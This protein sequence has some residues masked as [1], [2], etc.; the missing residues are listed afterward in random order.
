MHQIQ[1]VKEEAY[2]EEHSAGGSRISNDMQESMEC[3][4]DIEVED[5]NCFGLVYTWIKS[6]SKPETSILK[7]LDRAM[8]NS[9][10]LDKYG[11][12]PARFHPFLISDHSPVVLHIPNSIDKKKKSFI[13]SNFIVDKSQFKD[14]VKRI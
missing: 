7:K 13:V 5:V 10:F 8:V 2:V 12:A 3:V 4:N 9:D 6:P 1:D 14:V 11:K